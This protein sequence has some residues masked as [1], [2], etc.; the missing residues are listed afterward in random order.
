MEFIL[1]SSSPRR[2][3]L[4]E[5][6]GIDATV[7][8]ADLDE[9]PLAGEAA[10]PYVERLAVAKASA[11]ALAHAQGGALVVAAD[12]IVAIDGELLGKPVNDSEARSQLRRLSGRDHM[13]FTGVAV[14]LGDQIVSGVESTKVSF[15]SLSAAEIDWYIATGEPKGKAGGYAIQ[16][17]GGA[18]VAR[19]D[20]SFDNV[21]GLPRVLLNS[22]LSE[23]GHNLVSLA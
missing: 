12:T 6:L 10:E 13:V 5:Q 19:I 7:R 9:T 22:L 2:R 23:V 18:F 11:N 4:L 1:A 3:S 20:G 21:I 8:P 17:A 15:R 16:G 14:R